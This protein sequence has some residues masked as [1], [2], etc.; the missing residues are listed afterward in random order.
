MGQ[1]VLGYQLRIQLRSI[2]PPVWRR[3]V[4]AAD[5]TIAQLHEIIQLSMGWEDEHLHRFVIRGREYGVPRPGGIGFEPDSHRLALEAFGFRVHE[6]FVYEYDFHCAWLHDV[7]IEKI[8]TETERQQLPVCIAGVGGCPPE[9]SGPPE[10]FMEALDD[11]SGEDF[12]EW[13]EDLLEKPE[14]DRSELCAGLDAWRPW[15][16]RRF[17]CKAANARLRERQALQ[18]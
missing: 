1:P 14:L 10:R 9:D 4:V 3:I 15:I 6:R 16:D 11:H 8:L 17:D 5:A 18:S 13:I 12:V 7:R 2:S